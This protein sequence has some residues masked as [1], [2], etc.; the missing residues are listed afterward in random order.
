MAEIGFVPL[1]S[2]LGVAGTSYRIQL[3]EIN[4]K[5]AVRL[6]KGKDAIDSYVFKEEDV[7]GDFPNQNIIVGWVLRTVAIPNINPH[8]I[9]KTTQA[10]V[11]QAI[12]N[13]EEKKMI[14][15][16][17]EA[18][19]VELT[20]VPGSE[21]KRPQA[22]GW[23]KSEESKTQTE[24]EEERRQAFKATISAR[25][26]EAQDSTSTLK[27]TRN[28]PS[29][30]KEGAPEPTKVSSEGEFCPFCGKD[31]TFRFCPYC[32]KPLPH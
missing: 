11:K 23:V 4:E 21:L 25:K 5:W 7:Q 9:M 18:K 12:K 6:L 20:V 26:A 2:Q 19:E 31:L 14:P 22:Q 13:K 29:I 27:T 1:S 28:L 10:L 15:T 8:Q 30:P 24:I 16:V 3:G 32:G 17:T